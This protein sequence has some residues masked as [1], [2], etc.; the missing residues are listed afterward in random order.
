MHTDP[1]LASP[2]L[3][4]WL[5]PRPRP[6]PRFPC[7][8]AASRQWPIPLTLEQ[9]GGRGG[10]TSKGGEWWIMCSA[11]TR[12]LL[13]PSRDAATALD[14]AEASQAR[15]RQTEGTAARRRSRDGG[16]EYELTE[17]WTHSL[18]LLAHVCFR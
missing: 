9:R 4:C 6:A 18:R 17:W 15:K 2:A 12:V 8:A 3:P 16:E 10:K 11:S 13:S 14:S 5:S 7:A 1:P